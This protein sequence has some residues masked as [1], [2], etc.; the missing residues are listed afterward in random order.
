M[1][2]AVAKLREELRISISAREDGIVC[3]GT[4]E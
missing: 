2:R 3:T 4:L 1:S